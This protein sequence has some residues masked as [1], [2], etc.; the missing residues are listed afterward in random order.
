MFNNSIEV[1]AFMVQ[2][3]PLQGLSKQKVVYLSCIFS[4]FANNVKSDPT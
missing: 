3:I 4:F 2:G 1:M